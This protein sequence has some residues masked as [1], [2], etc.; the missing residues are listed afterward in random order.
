M[1]CFRI[2]FT[3]YRDVQAPD[4]GGELI[5]AH[6]ARSYTTTGDSMPLVEVSLP[7]QQTMVG[8][9]GSLSY[10]EQGINMENKFD[11][12]ALVAEL[13]CCG[14]ARM[15]CNRCCSGENMSMAHFTNTSHDKARTLA[16]ASSFPGDIVAMDLKTMPDNLVFT[17]NGSFMFG[18]KGTRVDVALADCK[19]ACCGAGLCFQKI[20]GNGM[21]YINAGGS[22]IKQSLRGETHRIDPA[23]LVA[24]TRGLDVSVMKAGTCATMCCGGE[25]VA[26]T[27]I[28][29]TGNYW[30]ASAP[31]SSQAAYAL[32]FLPP[33]K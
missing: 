23:S 25:G 33:K 13:G 31:F 7:P 12:G 21:V 20:D 26:L 1:A 19:Q 18:A 14:K 3:H 11:D 16:F 27:T 5:E 24:F 10:F 2:C 28:T 8:E 32:Q 17:M 30:L 15:S 4:I 9:V 22:V 29:G 6:D